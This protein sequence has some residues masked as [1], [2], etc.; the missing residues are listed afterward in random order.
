MI[1]IPSRRLFI[2]GL[3]ATVTLT[4]LIYA[5][6]L[7]GAVPVDFAAALGTLLLPGLFPN[8]GTVGWWIGMGV[9]FFLGVFVFPLVYRGIARRTGLRVPT[10]R[11]TEFGFLLWLAAMVIG[12]PLLGAGFF[13]M[14]MPE[15]F[16]TNVI[17]LLAHLAYGAVLGSVA[18]P[19]LRRVQSAEDITIDRRAA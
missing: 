19:T 16:V 2:G 14:Q 1:T 6:P 12:F 11:G 4:I 18:R 9:H 10:L 15:P 3:V 8:P 13:A 5:A 17:T 7:F